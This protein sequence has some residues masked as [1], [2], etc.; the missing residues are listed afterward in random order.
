MSRALAALHKRGMLAALTHQDAGRSIDKLLQSART[1][2][3]YCGF[4]P[5]ADSLHL[6]NLLQGFA[7][8]HFQCAGIRPILL[9]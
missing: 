9:V 1:P 2:A 7:L 6:G 4:D 8:R 5:T 3:V